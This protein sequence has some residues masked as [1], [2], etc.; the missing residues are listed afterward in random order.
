MTTY[1]EVRTDSGTFDLQASVQIAGKDVIVT[2]TGGV[3]HVGAVA[4]GQARPSLRDP[5]SLSAS[6]SVY[7]VVGHKEDMLAKRAADRLAAR[8][9]STVVVVAGIHWDALTADDIQRI[10]QNAT[11]LTDL[12]IERVLSQA[13][14]QTP[15]DGPLGAATSRRP[16]A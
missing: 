9:G 2:I 7:C 10:D 3:A 13:L 6:S 16:P 1:F 11:V 14:D 4:I 8:L 5:T 12:L 15:P